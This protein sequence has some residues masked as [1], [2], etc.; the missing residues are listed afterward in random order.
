MTDRHPAAVASRLRASSSWGTNSSCLRASGATRAWPGPVSMAVELA[1]GG[2]RQA[3]TAVGATAPA[4]ARHRGAASRTSWTWPR[5]VGTDGRDLLGGRA[6]RPGR[7][8]LAAEHR[9]ARWPGPSTARDRSVVG[10][11]ELGGRA[12]RVSDLGGRRGER[13][14]VSG[15]AHRLEARPGPAGRGG[16]RTRR[17]RPP[18]RPTPPARRATPAATIHLVRRRP[19]GFAHRVTR[20]SWR[21]RE[22]GHPGARGRNGRTG[23]IVPERP[24]RP[25]CAARSRRP[26]AGSIDPC[27]SRLSA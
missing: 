9:V 20:C 2:Q 14:R 19:C 8:Q 23:A 7:P 1:G 24:R 6:Q 13:G 10:G 18:R 21:G 5:N 11:G 15:V 3:R 27:R 25:R 4:R 26:R 12:V 17:R 22:R 16:R